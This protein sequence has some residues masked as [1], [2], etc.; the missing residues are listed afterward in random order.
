MTNKMYA[1][2]VST[3]SCAAPAQ[4]I[5]TPV[6][7]NPQY[8]DYPVVG[9]TWDMASNYCQWAQGQLPSEAQ[10]EKAA[11]GESGALY[12]WGIDNPS[13]SL[14]NYKGCLGHT[15]DVTDYPGGHSPYGAYGMAGNVFQWVN[16]FYDEHYYDSMPSRNPTGPRIRR[17]PCTPRLKF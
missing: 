5:G 16:D 15:S 4:E 17:L 13:C 14:S 9:V 11:R 7:S 8:G 10:W 3:G 6:Y 12:P 2:C 1:Q